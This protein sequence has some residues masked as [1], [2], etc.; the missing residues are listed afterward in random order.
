M[1]KMFNCTVPGAIAAISA[2][3]H[4]GFGL[5]SMQSAS[6]LLVFE[7]LVPF[8]CVQVE[9]QVK[10]ISHVFSTSWHNW[11]HNNKESHTDLLHLNI[12]FTYLL[13]QPTSAKDLKRISAKFRPRQDCN[14]QQ[15]ATRLTPTRAMG[16]LTCEL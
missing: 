2:A 5:S 8:I 11:Y 15:R 14:N 16:P 3:T 12:L 13:Q 4:A 10:L 7:I 6:R 1:Q 9:I